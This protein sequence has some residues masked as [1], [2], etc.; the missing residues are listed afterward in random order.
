MDTRDGTRFTD[1]EHSY[2]VL[3]QMRSRAPP[4]LTLA[5]P[6]SQMASPL[7]K[8]E[9]RLSEELYE[10]GCAGYRESSSYSMGQCPGHH[11]AQAATMGDSCVHSTLAPSPSPP[12][13]PSP[14]Q[15]AHA[16]RPLLRGSPQR[17]SRSPPNSR[18]R[19]LLLSSSRLL[20]PPTRSVTP[21]QEIEVLKTLDHVN[22]LH[23]LGHYVN[24]TADKVYM[25]TELLDGGEL[26]DAVLERGSFSEAD[27]RLVF[28]AVLQGLVYMHERGVIHR[29]VKARQMTLALADTLRS[30]FCLS[31]PVSLPSCSSL[32]FASL[33]RNRPRY[34]SYTSLFAFTRRL[35][36]PCH[37]I[38]AFLTLPSLSPPPPPL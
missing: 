20:R 16:A 30:S 23:L 4:R 36:S 35:A 33:P 5:L 31:P 10:T 37:T 8:P 28:R 11:T 25:V 15:S 34:R 9:P 6:I 27:A 12:S 29:D 26:L 21:F 14:T 18:P 13:S 2:I 32:R 38:N 19:C 7:K 24:K 22:V 1:S 17:E 3:T